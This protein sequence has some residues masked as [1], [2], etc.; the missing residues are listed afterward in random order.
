MQMDE[1]KLQKLKDAARN[2]TNPIKKKL[3]QKIAAKQQNET[4]IAEAENKKA[5]EDDKLR[6]MMGATGGIDK[7]ALQ[8]QLI[9]VKN[10]SDALNKTVTEE[11]PRILDL[12]LGKLRSL[13]CTQIWEAR[14]RA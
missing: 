13:F 9:A 1:D 14:N 12:M 7:K 11:K 8:E 6:K 4:D 10:A 3:L 5:E 2:E